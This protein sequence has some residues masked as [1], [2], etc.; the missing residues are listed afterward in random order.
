[1]PRCASRIMQSAVCLQR[2]LPSGTPLIDLMHEHLMRWLFDRWQAVTAPSVPRGGAKG[3]FEFPRLLREAAAH[4]QRSL[5]E[6]PATWSLSLLLCSLR[7]PRR[8]RP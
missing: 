6:L 3:L 1:M 5:E 7:E 8:G 2:S 4:L